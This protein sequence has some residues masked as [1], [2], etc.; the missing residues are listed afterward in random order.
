MS[1]TAQR[2]S[3]GMC[4]VSQARSRIW[5]AAAVTTR[6]RSCGLAGHRQV[7]LDGATIVEPLRVD[8]PPD[9]DG[10]VVGAHLVEHPLRVRSLHEELAERRQVEQTD[11]LTD[12]LMLLPRV[13]EPV[14]SAVAVVVLGLD[15]VRGIPVG[16][17]P[18]GH[19]AEA[20]TSLGQPVVQDRA[21]S[22][23]GRLGL[24]V[25]PVHRVEQSQRLDR[26]VPQVGRV[27]LERHHPANVDIPHVHRRMPVDD[28]VRHDLPGAAGGL[29]PDRV[30]AAGHEEPRDV[31]RLA[32]QI[33]VIG[34]E[35][36]GAVEEQLDPGLRQRRHSMRRALHHRLEMVEVGRQRPEGELLRNPPATALAGDGP[37]LG[38][39]LEPPDQQLARLLLEVGVAV[40]VAQDRHLRR[41]LF[42][43]LGHHVVVLRGV[44]RH[45]CADR[46]A[47]LAAPHPRGVH[48][49]VAADPVR[50]PTHRALHSH[51]TAALNQD[52]VDRGVLPDDDP[53]RSGS[54]G[55]R[56]RGVD[57][58]GHAVTGQEDPA[59]QV[60]HSREGDHLGDGLLVEQLHL[61]AED[62]GHRCLSL[63]L[64]EAF[65]IGRDAHRAGLTE[66]GGLTGLGLQGR[67]QSAGV[68]G[69][70]GQVVCRPQLPD[71]AGGVPRR[72]AGQLLA[73]QQHDIGHASS[74]EV[75][76]NAAADD[77]TAD[78][79]DSR[80]LG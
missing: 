30:E 65:R 27:V 7:G 4:S 46:A 68:L 14:L 59:D 6:K 26:P 22:A 69:E 54:L 12:R 16:P 8:D 48:H 38:N 53:R 80:A 62:P 10:H 17:L 66:S 73:L 67:E 57:R 43:G 77:P 1:V 23:A 3:A 31:R 25:R 32:Q 70:A 18:A 5:V 42:D 45:H 52:A 13:G 28:P 15:A 40:L 41:Q 60:V 37:W 49:H 78:D 21:P 34:G 19:D 47:E 71:Q 11:A 9:R 35:R 75:V 63:Q 33:A 55:Q 29:D 2:A 79:D 44:Q 72:T 61:Q 74:S 36:L 20:G 64:L 56:P 76:R 51:S 50:L 24:A 39:R 58:V